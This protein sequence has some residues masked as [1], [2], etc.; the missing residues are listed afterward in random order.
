MGECASVCSASDYWSPLQ[1][2]ANPA[3]VRQTIHAATTGSGSPKRC[4]DSLCMVASITI[5]P[6]LS[7]DGSRRTAIMR[8]QAEGPSGAVG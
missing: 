6:H 4:R 7:K 5:P 8:D 3:I 1:A 2:S